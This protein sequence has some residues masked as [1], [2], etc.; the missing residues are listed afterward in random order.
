MKTMIALPTMGSVPVQFLD[1][2]LALRRVGDCSIYRTDSSLVYDARNKMAK[3]AIRE[4]FDRVLW[5]DSDMVFAPDLM[6]RL[7]ARIDEGRDFV[8]GLYVRRK[9]PHEVTIFRETEIRETA[10]GL[11]ARAP[12]YGE[13]PKNGVFEIAAS[14]FGVTMTTVRLL[15]DVTEK[16]GLPFTPISGFGEDMAF[17]IRARQAGY[18]LWCDSGIRAGHAG[19]KVYWPEE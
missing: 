17:C 2:M 9:K 14:G 3:A 4:G 1:S 8:T 18:T 6:E 5:L 10:E 7:S 11:A 13:H 16:I 15:K 19:T 12:A